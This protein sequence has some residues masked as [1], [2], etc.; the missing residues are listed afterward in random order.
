MQ[1]SNNLK[2][3]GLGVHNFI[4]AKGKVPPIVIHTGRPSIM[5]LLM[6]YY[7]QMQQYDII[8][9]NGQEAALISN[10]SGVIYP[11]GEAGRHRAWWENL[12]QDQKNSLGS[13][14][15]WKCPSRRS[16]VQLTTTV[17]APLMGD[18]EEIAAGPVTDYTA[19]IFHI[20]AA[21]PSAGLGD[22]A[23]VGH[24]NSTDGGHINNQL[25]PFRVA[26]YSGVGN[27]DDNVPRDPIGYWADGTTNQLL[28]G[29]AHIPTNRLNVCQGPQWQT[30]ADC[31]ALTMHGWNR[32]ASRPI[33]PAYRLA[34]G[35]SDFTSDSENPI[36]TYS[37]GSNH[38]GVCGFLMGDGSVQSISST[39]P[40]Y[41]ILCALANVADGVSVS[42]P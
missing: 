19:V 5:I 33:H 23:W 15:M 39:T 7:E 30:Q 40:M 38:P 24:Y 8:M 12:P 4:S 13:V 18:A 29:E 17:D 2:Q 1:C 26:R 21:N 41:P 28:F 31:S 9:Q 42:I 16:G 37:F 36:G 3:F 32:G 25:G 6:P 14:S 27:V 20:N 34:K 35:P 10:S 22:S 11:G